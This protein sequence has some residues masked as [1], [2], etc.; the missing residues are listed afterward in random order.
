MSQEA[1]QA[2]IERSLRILEQAPE[3]HLARF[4]LANALFD[5]GR[6]GEAE[7]EY[8]RCLA[9]QP[10]W[11]AVAISLGRCLVMSGRLPEAR[12]VLASAREMAIR[13]GHTSPL[14]EIADLESRCR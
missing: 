4:S 14:E 2:R 13:Q 6:P 1:A 9:G 3:N 5:A 12:E 11:M 10:D 8:R 7:Q